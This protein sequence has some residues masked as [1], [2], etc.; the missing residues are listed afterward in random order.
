[1]KYNL[2]TKSGE[3]INKFETVSM[4]MAIEY[5]ARVKK[6]SKEDLLKIFKV[7]LNI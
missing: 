5:F 2:K 3:V 7:S 6:M 4:S 1:M